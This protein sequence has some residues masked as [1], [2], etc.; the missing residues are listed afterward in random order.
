MLAAMSG[1]AHVASYLLNLGVDVDHSDTSGNTALHY[2]VGYGW[3][4]CTKVLLDAGADPAVVNDWKVKVIL[5]H[6]RRHFSTV[7]G[8][9]S[10]RASG[11]EKLC[12]GSRQG[13]VWMT[14]TPGRV[15]LS[16]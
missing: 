11:C 15:A 14:N 3:Y 2:A 1:H 9:A 13:H 5:H 12:S 6:H 10:E 7:A 4:F 16:K 8:L